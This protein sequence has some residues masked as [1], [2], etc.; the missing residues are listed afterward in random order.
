MSTRREIEGRWWLPAKPEQIWFGT[1]A[2]SADGRL[3]LITKEAKSLSMSEIFKGDYHLNIEPLI[4]GRDAGDNPVTLLHCSD[5]GTHSSFGM[6]T[7]KIGIAFPLVGLEADAQEQIR[8]KRIIADFTHLQA[9]LNLSCMS[10]QEQDGTTHLSYRY[11]EDIPFVCS[12]GTCVTIRA[13]LNSKFSGRGETTFEFTERRHL[14]FSFLV[15]LSLPE[16][17]TRLLSFRWL[18]TLLIGRP[19]YLTKLMALL[20]D[21]L[22]KSKSEQSVELLGSHLDQSEPGKSPHPPEMLAS[23]VDVRPTFANCSTAGGFITSA[24]TPCSLFTFQFDL[25]TSS[26]ATIASSF[27]PKRLRCT[28]EP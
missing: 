10:Y 20:P 12:D 6:L 7:R 13:H 28:T 4:C 21:V 19:V 16:I 22:D 23:F 26:I 15:P 14:E 27:W 17:L 25:T 1:L 5:N 3:T 2:E 11:P 18:L 8:F 24:W 9:W